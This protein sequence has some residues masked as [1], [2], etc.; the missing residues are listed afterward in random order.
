MNKDLEVEE[1][2]TKLIK[3]VKE[4]RPQTAKVEAPKETKASKLLKEKQMKLKE[5]F[6]KEE[7]KEKEYLK[8]KPKQV[9]L[10]HVEP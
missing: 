1:N 5:K 6:E 7:E 9:K 4:V 3:P 10:A 8:K 2:I